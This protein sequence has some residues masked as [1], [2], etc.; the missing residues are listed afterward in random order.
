[1]NKILFL[2]TDPSCKTDLLLASDAVRAV[3][4]KFRKSASF[5]LFN[6]DYSPFCMKEVRARLSESI[7]ASDAI[8]FCGKRNESIQDFSLLKE[9]LSL[10]SAQYFSSGKCICFPAATYS[11]TEK[12]GIVEEVTRTN[13]NDVKKAA[14]LAINS[15]MHKKGLLLCTDSKKEADELIYNAFENVPADI[16]G[17]S[18][19]HFDFEEMLSVLLYK[20]PSY[21]VIFTTQ[22]K[23]GIFASHINSLNKFP[24]SY[25]VLHGDSLRIYKREFLPYEDLSNLPYAS[26]LMCCASMIE[27]ELGFKSA[28]MQLCK[29]VTRTLEKCAFESRTEFQKHLLIEINKPIRHRQVKTNESNN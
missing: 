21:D 23:A 22:D 19:E 1:M 9:Y 3:L 2:Y 5:S 24:A 6:I 7:S 11:V 25:T 18:V 4:R 17:I 20:V 14:V 26:C 8:I 27:N 10:H 15:A 28:G 12:D 13:I 29:A 16:R